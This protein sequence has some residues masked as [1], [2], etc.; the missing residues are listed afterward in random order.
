LTSGVNIQIAMAT[1]II[2]FSKIIKEKMY[3]LLNSNLRVQNR[4]LGKI[5]IGGTITEVLRVL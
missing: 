3:F 4:L 5:G 2:G 1:S